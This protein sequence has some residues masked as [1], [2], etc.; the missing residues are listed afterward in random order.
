MHG[1]RSGRR[2]LH[3]LCP[4][5]LSARLEGNGA[6][7]AGGDLVIRNPFGCE[8]ATG[9]RVHALSVPVDVVICATVR[10]GE[11]YDAVDVLSGEVWAGRVEGSES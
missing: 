6:G 8:L 7:G 4:A 2:G 5:F 1:A 9:N 3:E 11:Q 10:A